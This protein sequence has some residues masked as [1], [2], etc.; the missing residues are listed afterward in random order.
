[1]LFEGKSFPPNEVVGKALNDARQW[2]NVQRKLEAEPN[3]K[4]ET[5]YQWRPPDEGRAMC[6]VIA[7]EGFSPVTSCFDAK[8][9]CWEW[10]LQ[11][12]R[13]LRYQNVTFAGSTLEITKAM[14][15]PL[16][17]SALMGHVAGLL[18]FTTNKIGWDISYEEPSSNTGDLLGDRLSSYVAR[19]VQV[20][21]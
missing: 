17:W 20:S 11:S 7:E 3:R 6:F 10:A 9:N 18:S 1:M 5:I 8:V 16:Q 21:L 14:F 12:M 2:F 13:D 4:T 15:E 19:G